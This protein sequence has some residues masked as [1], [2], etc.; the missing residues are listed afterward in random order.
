[1]GADDANCRGCQLA[2]VIASRLVNVYRAAGA[3]PEWLPE[4]CCEGQLANTSAAA[5]PVV[6]A[7][8]AQLQQQAASSAAA[9]EIHWQLAEHHQDVPDCC[10]CC[11]WQLAW[12]WRCETGG[13]PDANA[14]QEVL[15]LLKGLHKCWLPP[16]AAA[17]LLLLLLM[18]LVVALLCSPGLQ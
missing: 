16:Q 7:A 3:V 13:R 2:A 17:L 10:Y 4:S 9:D 8:P 6:V 1:M 18:P 12:Q 14:A 15:L 5:A 11:C